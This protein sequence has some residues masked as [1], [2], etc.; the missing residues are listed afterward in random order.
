MA[1]SPRLG[2]PSRRC[3]RASRLT[4]KVELRPQPI[5]PFQIPWPWAPSGARLLPSS[6]PA[7]EVTRIA[8][9]R[10]FRCEFSRLAALN[11]RNANFCAIIEVRTTVSPGHHQE[12]AGFV[13]ALPTR[14]LAH[15]SIRFLFV[16]TA[17][18][19][20]YLGA[21]AGQSTFV[22]EKNTYL[23]NNDRYILPKLAPLQ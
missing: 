22:S 17:P 7:R 21:L 1:Q 16:D 23:E 9:N 19:K 11:A 2:A 15:S 8:R 20:A 13:N 14:S 3:S 12:S 6:P 10:L 5:R 18:A 4:R